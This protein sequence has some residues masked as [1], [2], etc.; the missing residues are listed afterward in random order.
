TARSRAASAGADQMPGR[1]PARPRTPA[2]SQAAA[3]F[4]RMRDRATAVIRLVPPYHAGRRL[5]RQAAAAAPFSS[6][7]GTMVRTDTATATSTPGATVPAATVSTAASTI[8]GT[9]GTPL[10]HRAA[11]PQRRTTKANSV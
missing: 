7:A 8:P 6:L 2:A 10:I 4:Q 11:T 9:A 1:R 5:G 3:A